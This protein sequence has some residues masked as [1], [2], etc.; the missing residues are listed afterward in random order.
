MKEKV[1]MKIKGF[2]LRPAI[3][4][5]LAVTL[6]A[7][8]C[9]SVEDNTRSASLLTIDSIEGEPGGEGEE[10]GV[11]LLSDV[12]DN[13]ADAPQDP[14]TC[15][16]F[17]DNA[18][19]QVSNDFL[20]IGPGSGVGSP[21]IL[22]DVVITQYRVDYFRPNNRN[23][24]GIDVPFGIDGTMTLRV[25]I[26]GQAEAVVLVVRH[27]AK[28]EPPLAE[29]SNGPSEGILTANAQIKLFGRDIAGRTVSATGF[30]EIHWAN[31]GED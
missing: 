8:A 27:I 30:L 21:S 29:L 12:C 16:V 31:Y 3:L 15:S 19:I 11:P 13:P 22:N 23:T 24:P 9:T 4:I 28:R 2:S 10:P 25:P 18:T 14:E 1:K 7:Y 5:L 26:N 20:Q 6:L 17:N